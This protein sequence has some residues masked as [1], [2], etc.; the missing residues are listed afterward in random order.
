M[1][2]VSFGYITSVDENGARCDAVLARATRFQRAFPCPTRA[3]PPERP[4]SSVR[5][6]AGLSVSEMMQ[7]YID[8][9]NK[10]KSL[11]MIK[12]IQF[13]APPRVHLAPRAARLAPCALRLARAGHTVFAPI[14]V[15]RFTENGW[16]K[17]L[18][19]QRVDLTAL[20]GITPPPPADFHTLGR[21]IE[22]HIRRLGW[23]RCL[24]VDFPKANYSVRVWSENWMSNV[25]HGRKR[26]S[27]LPAVA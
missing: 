10:L 6:H 17:E 12:E 4:G 11:A 3:Q 9:P 24:D 7:K 5:P 20:L 23:W 18:T 15:R 21:M 27:A 13:G 19:Q 2:P 16:N 14:W 8:D 26:T 22:G 25:R 1:S